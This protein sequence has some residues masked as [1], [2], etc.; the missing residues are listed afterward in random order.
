MRNAN[1]LYY[2]LSAKAYGTAM[3]SSFFLT[4]VLFFT[5]LISLLPYALNA[6]EI[7]H[8]RSIIFDTQERSYYLHLPAGE[9]K[10]MPLVIVLHGLG[11]FAYKLRFGIGLDRLASEM[12]FAVVFAQGAMRFNSS[13]SHWSAG[14]AHSLV[15]DVGFLTTLTEQLIAQ[16]G[17]DHNRV[18]VLGISNGGFMA[19]KL[20]CEHAR[21][22]SR[23]IVVAGSIG[24]Q[25]WQD[26]QPENAPSVLHIHGDSDPFFPLDSA[27]H[28]ASTFRSPSLPRLIGYWAALAAL[29]P[30]PPPQDF[31][32]V[33][34][35]YFAHPDTDK[36][37]WLA[38]LNNFGHDW[39]HHK[40][41]AVGALP[42]I[43]HY[44]SQQFFE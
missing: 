7:D 28:W 15:D 25:D 20:A 8:R 32:K 33:D 21:L 38:I 29:K 13:T 10:D 43:R 11:G 35:R 39:P 12:G 36:V 37:V 1:T 26:C 27:F 5:M 16:Y 14:F 17:F 31:N 42:L 3:R 22:F 44:L 2:F 30:A 24:G 34:S 41:H 9:T 19:Y 40:N 4:Y 18:A 6:R 23:I